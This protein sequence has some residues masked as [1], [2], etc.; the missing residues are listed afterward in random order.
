LNQAVARKP[1]NVY[2]NASNWNW[3]DNTI[4][5]MT[6][7]CDNAIPYINNILNYNIPVWIVSG[8]NDIITSYQSQ[9]DA[10][11][12]LSWN[13]QNQ[14]DNNKKTPIPWWPTSSPYTGLYVTGG[15]LNLVVLNNMGHF[16]MLEDCEWITEIYE[17][18]LLV[19]GG[20]TK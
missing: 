10:I 19:L 17:N 11:S 8:T 3:I 20:P 9:L 13:S 2:V 6:Q 7:N 4:N 5:I 14:W 16:F 15:G 18:M 1:L 12:Q